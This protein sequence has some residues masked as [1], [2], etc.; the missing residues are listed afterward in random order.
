MKHK[1]Y[2]NATEVMILWNTYN[3]SFSY[4]EAS[5]AVGVVMS[6]GYRWIK[7]IQAVLAG[8][9]VVRL[10]GGDILRW[11]VRKIKEEKE[12]PA[13]FQT[14]TQSNGPISQPSTAETTEERVERLFSELKRAIADLALEMANERNKE[15]IEQAKSSNIIGTIKKGWSTARI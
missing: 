10:R 1:K 2:L 8:E 4:K 14:P 12:N 13:G 7:E 11:V 6:T 9:K 5:D 3:R 15:I